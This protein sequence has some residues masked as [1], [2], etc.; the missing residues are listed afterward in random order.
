M[1]SSLVPVLATV[2]RTASLETTSDEF[3]VH[4]SLGMRQRL[5]L[6]WIIASHHGRGTHLEVPL[7]ELSVEKWLADAPRESA[8]AKFTQ[9]SC[10]R[11][12]PWLA[13]GGRLWP[14]DQ[15]METP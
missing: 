7:D 5:H 3:V 13:S 9:S 15:P 11:L 12:S 2:G 1:C 8:P 4:Y 14:T 10:A 6:D